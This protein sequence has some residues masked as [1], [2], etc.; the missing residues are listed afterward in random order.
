MGNEARRAIFGKP[1]KNSP[2]I[3]SH[4][5]IIQNH[6]DIISCVIMVIMIG[7]MFQVSFI[8]YKFLSIKNI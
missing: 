3:L 4:E 8:L 5:F 2:P 6:G 7:F 1:K